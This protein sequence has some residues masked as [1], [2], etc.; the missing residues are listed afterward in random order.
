MVSEWLNNNGTSLTWRD[1]ITS[2]RSKAEME[3]LVRLIESYQLKGGKDRWIIKD[4]PQQRF[5][6]AWFRDALTKAMY[7]QPQQTKKN[8]WIN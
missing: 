8:R 3:N 6:T 7:Q 4:T 1:R 5:T 2:G